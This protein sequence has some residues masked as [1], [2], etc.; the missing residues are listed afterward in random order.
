VSVGLGFTVKVLLFFSWF[1]N[2]RIRRFNF[3]IMT[4]FMDI[5]KALFLYFWT[6]KVFFFFLKTINLVNVL[7]NRISF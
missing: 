6:L 7:I 4:L 5:C 1:L 3:Y 2:L